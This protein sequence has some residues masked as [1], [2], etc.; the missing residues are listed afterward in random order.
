MKGKMTKYI[1]QIPKLVN[2]IFSSFA[3]S[4]DKCTHSGSCCDDG[5]RKLNQTAVKIYTPRDLKFS[6]KLTME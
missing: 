3:V 6:Y 2:Q 1:K 4:Y 5:E